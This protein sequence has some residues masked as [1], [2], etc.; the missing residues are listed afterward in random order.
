[1]LANVAACI[2]LKNSFSAQS[3]SPMSVESVILCILGWGWGWGVDNFLS[4]R[5]SFVPYICL[6][7]HHNAETLNKAEK[8]YGMNKNIS[9]VK[10]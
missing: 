1:M 4:T 10:V 6:R 8:E 7:R 3:M 5:R 2:L 9:L